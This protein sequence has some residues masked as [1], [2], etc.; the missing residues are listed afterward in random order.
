MITPDDISTATPTPDRARTPRRATTL[1]VAAGVLGGGAIG[2]MFAIPSLTSAATT[3]TTAPAATVALAG[4]TPADDTP[5]DAAQPDPGTG[6]RDLLQALV[7]DGT[8][9][10][11]QAD[12]VTEYLVANRPERGPGGEMGHGHGHRRPG[13]D[14]AVVAELLGVDAATLRQDLRSG[15]TIAEI[16]AAQ[17]VDVQIVIDALVAEAQSHLDLDVTEGR[18][19]QAEADTRLTEITARVTD[20]VNNG[21]P[22]RGPHDDD[23]D[24]AAVDL[25]S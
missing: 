19:T 6:L 18:I 2:L 1:G 22:Q 21:M 25:G 15:Q 11:A 14:G 7:D 23:A 9:T 5:A 8:L 13:F 3:E 16:A 12:T 17:G 24:D 10:A 20:F 4:D